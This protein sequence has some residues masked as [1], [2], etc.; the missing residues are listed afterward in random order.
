MDF[1]DWEP[2]YRAILTDFGYDR[3]GDERARDLLA[4]LLPSETSPSLPAFFDGPTSVAVAGAGP[5]LESDLAVARGAD[6]VF[7]ASTAAGRL[8]DRDVSVDCVVTDLDKHADTV[9][10]LTHRGTPVAVHAHGDNVELV[11]EHVPDCDPGFLVPTT[12]AAPVGPVRNYGGF[13]DGDR[14]A[15]LADHLGAD[16]LVFPGWDFD[17]DGVAAEKAKKLRWAER[18]LYWLE[19]RREEQFALLDGRR[20]A[21]DTGPLPVE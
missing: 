19:R 1:D 15:F 20:E 13:T 3:T 14:A 18:L 10:E 2:V 9:S 12:Q 5:S 4:E 16:S 17:D 7:A 11:R 21:I 8:L 6:Q